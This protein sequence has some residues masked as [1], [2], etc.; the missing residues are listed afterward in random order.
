MDIY[1]IFYFLSRNHRHRQLQDS[2]AHCP[3]NYDWKDSN[4][5]DDDDEGDGNGDTDIADGLAVVDDY[6]TYTRCPHFVTAV[7]EDEWANNPV[8]NR[9]HV[10]NGM[11]D[12]LRVTMGPYL[13]AFE[14]TS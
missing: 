11:V 13:A 12:I 1:R 14:I 3:S 4:D 6:D 5:E 7:V 8:Y 10:A 2:V 9:I